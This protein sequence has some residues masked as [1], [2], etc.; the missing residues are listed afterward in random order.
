MGRQIFE[1]TL[2]N[3]FKKLCISRLQVRLSLNL[4]KIEILIELNYV[5]DRNTCIAHMMATDLAD[6]CPDVGP[7]MQKLI[8]H[9][10]AS[11]KIQDVIP[12]SHLASFK[13]TENE[14]KL[15]KP[16]DIEESERLLDEK[17]G[18]RQRLGGLIRAMDEAK[19]SVKRNGDIEEE[20]E[21]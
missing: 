20:K 18:Q 10:R 8:P 15:I 2:Q 4:G 16:E 5:L 3:K 11:F 21:D 17:K 14:M 1:I 7:P 9:T 6:Q 19:K 12:K 13:L